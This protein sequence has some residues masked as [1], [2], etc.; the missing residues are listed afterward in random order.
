MEVRGSFLLS[1]AVVVV[2]GT[3]GVVFLSLVLVVTKGAELLTVAVAEPPIAVGFGRLL[4]MLPG[5]G[6]PVAGFNI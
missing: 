6:A 4:V 1:P 3:L 5:L 2:G